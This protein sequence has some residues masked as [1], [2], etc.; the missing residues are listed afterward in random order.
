MFRAPAPSLS[1]S[2][3][4][5]RRRTRRL[6]GI[7]LAAALATGLAAC[8][9]PAAGSGSSAA[10]S[11]RVVETAKGKVTVP[12]HPLRIVSVHSWTTESLLDFGEKPVGVE[13]GGSQY[14]PKRYFTAWNATKKVTSGANVDLEAIAALKPDLI[15]GVD[16]P[17]LD[18]L[19]KQL[20]QIAP[21]AFA[22]FTDDWTTYP[23]ATAGF[24]NNPTALASLKTRYEDRIQTDKKKY[25]K[26]LAS[27]SFDVIQGGFDNGNYW[28]YGPDSAVGSVLTQIGAHF[29]TASAAVKAG[30]TNSVSYE[31]ADLLADAGALVYYENNDGTPANNIQ[32][33]FSLQ[34]FKDLKASKDKLVI[35]TPDFLP[36]SY[37]DGMGILDSIEKALDNH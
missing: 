35:G 22:K 20:S 9:T 13:N 15:V 5:T 26:V 37:S 19:Y 21:T 6:A 32:N 10:S 30:G 24:V 27:T 28:I 34:T 23:Q 33:L 1:P 14:V 3:R 11:T 2:S 18:K 29:G 31:K 36:G 12:T 4:Q 25:A 7:A 17:Y 16:V 8:S